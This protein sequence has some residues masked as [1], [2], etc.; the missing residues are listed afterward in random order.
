MRAAYRMADLEPAQVSLLRMPCH[1]YASGRRL[2]TAQYGTSFRGPGGVPIGSVNPNLGHPMTAAGIA[3]LL[4]LLGAFAARTRP[5]T[6]HVNKSQDQL[7]LLGSSPFRLLRANEA[8]DA[9]GPRVAA[10]SAFG[11]GGNNAHLIWKSGPG[12]LLCA[13]FIRCRRL[14]DRH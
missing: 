4:K 6:L 8:W 7:A 13:P 12:K 9:G 14:L 10:L 3:G 5:A 2:R 11:F 1:R